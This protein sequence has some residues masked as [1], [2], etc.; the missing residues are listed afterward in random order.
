MSSGTDQELEK[1]DWAVRWGAECYHTL[2]NVVHERGLS[3]AIGDELGL[4]VPI[5]GGK[6]Y[7]IIVKPFA[8]AALKE[9][10]ER[11]FGELS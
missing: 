4:S 10:I 6:G 5:M 9:K 2:K 1:L 3:T 11:V 7:S 8:P